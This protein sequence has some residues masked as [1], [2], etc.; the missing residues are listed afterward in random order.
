MKIL[1]FGLFVLI[2]N[3]EC[4]SQILKKLGKELSDDAR[5]RVRMKANQKMNEALD[6]VLAQ[7]KKIITN[8][9]DKSAEKTSDQNQQQ[10]GGNPQQSG[11][12]ASA[13]SKEDETQGYVTIALSAYEVFGTGTV[14]ITGNSLKYGEM[15]EVK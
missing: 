13:N 7:P 1:L 11:M 10:N 9:K 3:N 15:K 8:K 5:W 12:N 6:T 2:V 4:H 14:K